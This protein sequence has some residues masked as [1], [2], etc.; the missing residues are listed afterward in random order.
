MLLKPNMVIAGKE[1][2]DQAQVQEVA[3]ATLRCLRRHVPAALHAR[4]A[5]RREIG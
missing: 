4:Q 1:C 3:A 2:P 5:A